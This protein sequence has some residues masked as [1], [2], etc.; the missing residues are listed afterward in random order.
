MPVKLSVAAFFDPEAQAL[1]P[2]PRQRPGRG[3]DLPLLLRLRHLAV[4]SGGPF[5]LAQVLGDPSQDVPVLGVRTTVLPRLDGLED[6]LP[7][8]GDPSR[9]GVERGEGVEVLGLLPRQVYSA[10]GG[11]DLGLARAAL[12][13]AEP[14]DL[15][16]VQ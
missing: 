12:V 2:A 7:R 6:R 8:L 3:G 1:Q 15:V 5:L 13:E 16:P 9:L 4:D 14:G 11:L 10:P